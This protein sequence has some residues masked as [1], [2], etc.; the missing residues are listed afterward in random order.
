MRSGAMIVAEVRFQD[1]AQVVFSKHDYVVQTL[2]ADG[3]DQ[4][5][6]ESIL[7]R[8]ARRRDHFLDLHSR[9]SPPKL[10]AVDLVTISQQEPRS[11]LIWKSLDDL[12][13]SPGGGRMLG[14]VEVQHTTPVVR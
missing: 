1:P 6:H 9:H 4:S 5:L 7:P 12:L 3:A 11:S 10:L 14:H 13:H 8:A 2:S